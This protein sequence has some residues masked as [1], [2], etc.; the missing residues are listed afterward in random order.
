MDRALNR[1]LGVFLGV[2]LLYLL[3]L[4]GW[5]A[6]YSV[7]MSFQDVKL[8]NLGTV[9]RPSVGFAHYSA[10]FADPLFGKVV[11]NTAIFVGV[12]ALLQNGLGLA[13]AM[14]F[15]LDFP[16]ARYMRGLFLAAWMLPPLVIGAVWKWQFASDYGVV[17]W[18]LRS[19]GLV[20]DNIHWLSSPD[21]A[22]AAVTVANVWFGTPFAMIL[23]STALVGIPKSLYEAARVDGASAWL[24]FRA[25]TLPMI[26]GTLFAVVC[27]TIIYTMRAFDL[28]WAMTKGGPVDATNVLPLWSFKLS[29]D[30][31]EFGK[32]AAVANLAF[33]VSVLVGVLYTRTIRQEAST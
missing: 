14:F 29:F 15:N 27:L 10:V 22:L 6:L 33:L 19:L 23:L 16:G 24:R 5:P 9:F 11:R 30:Q 17:N 20:G 18:L 31:F 21:V 12:N 26:A 3:L 13:L 32:G 4:V 1:K 7:L 2:P 28:I 8:L 25:I